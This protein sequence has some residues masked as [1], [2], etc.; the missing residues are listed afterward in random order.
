MSYHENYSAIVAQENYCLARQPICNTESETAAYEL[1]YRNN[2]DQKDARV[3]CPHEATARVLTLAFMDIGIKPLAGKLPVFVNMTD[4]LL[5]R[6]DILPK[7]ADQIVLEVLEDIPPT[8]EILEALKELKS[9]GYKIALD[10]FV[11]NP[12]TRAFLPYADII[13]LDVMSCSRATLEKRVTILKRLPGVVLLAEKVE[14][15]DEFHE[16]KEMGFDL[17]QGYFLSRPEILNNRPK[18]DSGMLIAQL[19]AEIYKADPDVAEL[20]KLISRDPQLYYRI[21]KYVNSALYSLPNEISSLRHAITLLGLDQL[22]RIVSMLALAGSSKRAPSLM[23]VALIRAK[24]CQNLAESRGEQNAESFFT[25]GLLSM[26]DAF[27]QRPMA[28][29]LEDLPLQKSIKDALL[30]HSG[31]GGEILD[32]VITYEKG[33]WE[34]LSSSEEQEILTSA[35]IQSVIWADEVSGITSLAKDK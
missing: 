6:K 27:F 17:F 22:K 32:T 13:K 21:I 25:I 1:L 2:P 31:K 10:D 33:M 9:Q 34:D 28:T 5:L 16:C 26:L 14:T 12:K 19:L 15:W 24:M 30:T 11:L 29:I 20:E 3:S 18:A 23:P 8:P 7:P 35:Y 4:E